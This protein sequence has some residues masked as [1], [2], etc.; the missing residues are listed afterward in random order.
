VIGLLTAGAGIVIQILS[1]ADYP[2][3][4]AGLVILLVAAAIVAS[5]FRWWAPAV[6]VVVGLFLLIAGTITSDA[7]D[8]LSNPGDVGEFLGMMVQIVGVVIAILAG[9]AATHRGDT[10]PA[11]S[12]VSGHLVLRS[13]GETM[14]ARWCSRP[15]ALWRGRAH[16]I[17]DRRVDEGGVLDH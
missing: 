4:P 13:S 2:V 16:Q 6:G 15:A 11:P 1:G 10:W 14:H 7:R 3:V 12:R 8:R 9:I 5:R 17:C